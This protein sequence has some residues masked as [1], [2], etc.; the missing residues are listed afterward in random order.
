MTLGLILD[1]FQLF[2]EIWFWFRASK[3]RFDEDEDFKTRSREAVTKLQGGDEEFLRAWRR[4]CDASRQEFQKIYD[5]L[6]VSL[7][8]FFLP[9]STS[10]FSAPSLILSDQISWH[11][12]RAEYLKVVT[13]SMP[14]CLPRGA[15]LRD[16][17]IGESK[18]LKLALKFVLYIYG[19]R[20]GV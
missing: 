6:G 14:W 2:K 9:P 18:H 7:E 20:C 19:S 16:P 1:W 12:N 11:L 5:R 4:I 17:K 3:K 8:V 15:A 10:L 13:E